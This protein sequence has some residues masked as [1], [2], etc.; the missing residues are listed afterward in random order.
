MAEQTSSQVC[1]HLTKDQY[2]EI[3]FFWEPSDSQCVAAV[4]I[5]EA[6]CGETDGKTNIFYSVIMV[7]EYAEWRSSQI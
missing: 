7:N 4:K 1:R 2:K 6:T 3:N 5:N